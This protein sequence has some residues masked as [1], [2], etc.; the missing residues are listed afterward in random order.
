MKINTTEGKKSEEEITECLVSGQ[1]GC[2]LQRLIK[3]TFEFRPV[4]NE[5]P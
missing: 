5:K 3:M 4:V 2:Y 1:A